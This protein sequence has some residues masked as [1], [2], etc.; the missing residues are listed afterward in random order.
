LHLFQAVFTESLRERD[1]LLRAA[2]R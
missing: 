2:P 1:A